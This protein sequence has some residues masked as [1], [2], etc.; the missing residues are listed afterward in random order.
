MCTVRWYCVL[1]VVPY[2]LYIASG[3]GRT[4]TMPDTIQILRA[5]CVNT[6]D[7][8]QYR[9]MIVT[10]PVLVARCVLEFPTIWAIVQVWWRGYA[11]LLYDCAYSI[12]YYVGS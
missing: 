7:S 10:N 6:D 8:V 2:V 1:V 5:R 3:Y 11:V 4:S 12:Q 9:I